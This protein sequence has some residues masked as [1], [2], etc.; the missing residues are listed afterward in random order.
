MSFYILS[1]GQPVRGRANTKF[2]LTWCVMRAWEKYLL[3]R[4]YITF[5]ALT[6]NMRVRLPIYGTGQK[7]AH[8]DTCQIYYKISQNGIEWISTNDIYSVCL[9]RKEL[10]IEF[11]VNTI[12]G[13]R[14]IRTTKCRTEQTLE[15]KYT[16]SQYKNNNACCNL[17]KA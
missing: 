13:C 16:G 4:R 12:F 9:R 14:C 11:N 1:T 10:M 6:I 17:L 7:K 2:L 8:Q 5:E 3:L 15:P